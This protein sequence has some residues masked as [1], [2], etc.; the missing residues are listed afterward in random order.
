M[1]PGFLDVI[2]GGGEAPHGVVNAGE[3]MGQSPAT[4]QTNHPGEVGA[5]RMQ[6]LHY[7]N[8]E[9]AVPWQLN[10]LGLPQRL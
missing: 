3:Q 6:F 5:M 10:H 8:N 9:G 4:D 1:P 2:Y 7:F